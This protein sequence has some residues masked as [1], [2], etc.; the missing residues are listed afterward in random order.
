M[1]YRIGIDAGSKTVKVVVVEEDGSIVHSVYR[2]HRADI[3]TTLGEV[4]HDLRWRC[5]DLHGRMAVTGSAGIALSELLGLPFVQEV[6]ATTRAVRDVYPGA[7][8]IIELGGEDAKV[9]YLTG[10]LEQRMNA[11]CAGG[12]GGF[13]DTIAFMLGVRPQDMSGLALGAS[14]LYPIASRC[15]V[16]AQTDV[17]PL[18][19]AGAKT[20][21]VAASVLEAV[22]RQTL[23]GLA[24][25]RPLTGT[26]VFLGGPLEHIPDLVSR[27]RS[28]L[29]LTH[30]TGIKPRDAHLFAA[31]GAALA[32]DDDPDRASCDRAFS[33]IESLVSE[34]VDST[35]D[36]GHFP[37]LFD[38]EESLEEFFARHGQ[39]RMGRSRLAEASGPLF[40][41]VDAG[42]TTVKFAVVD[43]EGMLAYSDYRPTGGDVLKTASDMLADL[44]RA[45]PRPYGASTPSVHIA[46]ATVT[47]YGEDLLRAGL[48]IDSGIVET[49]AHLRAAQAF[50][51]DVSF[52]LDIGG[53]DMKALW[54]RDGMIYDA[55]LNE[56]CS[57]GCGA[58][59]EGT[60]HSLHISPTGF[61]DAALRAPNP[62]D[63]GTKC[64]VF[65]NSRVRHAQ[66]AGVLLGDLAAGVAYSVVH[67][68]VYR[69]IGRR[70]AASIGDVAV[71]QGG[72]F[73]S[74]AVLRAFELISG[75][76]AVRPDTAHLMGA[77]GAALAARDRSRAVA[78]KGM[79]PRSMLIEEGAVASLTPKRS[80]A[81]CC[82]CE[83]SCALSIVTFEDARSL[84]SGNRCNRAYGIVGLSP[85]PAEG[86]AD[87][88]RLEGLTASA[89]TG[90]APNVVALERSLLARLK[91]CVATGA[92]G[93]VH[94][95]LMTSFGMYEHLPFWHRLFSELGFSIIVPS[96][97][98]LGARADEG[99]ETIP[100][101]SACQSAR[102]THRR[103]FDLA[104][105]GA[106]AVFMPSYLRNGRCPVTS[107]YPNAVRDSV[108]LVSEG[109]LV[110]SSPLLEAV[111]PKKSVASDHDRAALFT[112][113]SELAPAGSPIG[114]REF[115]AAVDAALIAQQTFEKTVVRGAER[116][117]AWVHADGRRHGIVLAC[118]PY[119]IDQELSHGIDREMERLG[120]AVLPPLG[121]ADRARELRRFSRLTMVDDYA[122]T[123]WPPAK[124][125]IGLA[126]LVARDPSLDLVFLQSFGCGYDA[127]NADEAREALSS[128]G[129]PATVLKIDDMVD[130]AHVRIRLRTLAEA[131]A[132]R[133]AFDGKREVDPS[134]PHDGEFDGRPPLPEAK[135]REPVPWLGGI[136]KADVERARESM[137]PDVCFTAAVL[138]ARLARTTE[139]DRSIRRVRVPH[140]CERCLIDA[141][142]RMAKRVCGRVPEIE[143]EDGWPSPPARE[144]SPL[145]SSSLVS[146]G[147]A[148]PRV[149]IV[150]NALLCFDPL[151]NDGLADSIDRLGCEPVLPDPA[152]LY[153]DDVRYLDQLDEFSA[154]GVRHVLYL[155]SF[156]CLK[157]HVSARGAMRALS[158]RYPDMPVTTLDYDPETSAL[159]RE[160]RIRLAIAAAHQSYNA[161][162]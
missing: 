93:A 147:A 140:V 26:V 45:L 104:Q 97:G 5:G 51:P 16:F 161:P 32:L 117:L 162:R 49:A 126:S 133:D 119:H 89:A 61:A 25:G 86:G 7:D 127:L 130:V 132:A 68:V 116:A 101:E 53:Q 113:L 55:V 115:D 91:G 22:T 114:A 46:H 77:I 94:V 76:H 69:I 70:K 107:G 124:H 42:S 125:T 151:M 67:N 14:R 129:R 44:Y 105:H 145:L 33:E 148:R 81:R 96:R 154:Q 100:S 160:N 27:F 54:V 109:A 9:V 85:V 17:R 34:T 57:S 10:G 20:S 108:P 142:P 79:S 30:E 144:A 58:F 111:D 135:R 52:V 82:G 60:A 59:V 31:K 136:E 36:L 87:D 155:L 3:R 83:N 141:V 137:N 41:G 92:R 118:R 146:S 63:L 75:I 134:R 112:C 35:D 95:G 66:K 18:L 103:L 28:A 72:A 150:G 1:S 15:A 139:A 23:S 71:V 120:F 65:M 80:T 99:L 121:L 64:T 11:T 78:D 12:T 84:L 47:G 152:K 21:D 157:G 38:D 156:G 39:E 43:D 29:G 102:I 149:G 123:P 88:S 50:R 159:N 8:A 56:A 48:K 128:S 158:R 74:D 40:L 37:P 138:A 131:I 110:L 143:W 24:C 4:L 98:V 13:I 62:V 106:D 122:L 6:V 90:H 19:N 73:K 2:R 153:V